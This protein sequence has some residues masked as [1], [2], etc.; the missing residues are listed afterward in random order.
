M[1]VGR[2]GQLDALFLSHLSRTRIAQ[3]CDDLRQGSPCDRDG[4]CRVRWHVETPCRRRRRQHSQLHRTIRRPC[5]QPRQLHRAHP[6]LRKCSAILRYDNDVLIAGAGD[7]LTGGAGSAPLCSIPTS[8]RSRSRTLTW[9]ATPW[10]STIFW[11]HR[12]VAR[13]RSWYGCERSHRCRCQSVGDPC[14]RTPCRS[15]G[16]YERLS[17][18]WTAAECPIRVTRGLEG[19][20]AQ[21][22]FGPQSN[23]FSAEND[24]AVA[25]GGSLFPNT[26]P[27]RA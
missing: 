23:S 5:Q 14:K 8:G 2:A 20:P 25:V 7:S 13:P 24:N 9:T 11:S 17:P 12:S 16:P 1:K 22:R 3:Y 4:D 15:A 18:F 27:E 19:L 6:L 21:V 10:H 26:P